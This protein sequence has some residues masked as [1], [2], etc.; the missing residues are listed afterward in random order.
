MKK[1]LFQ[2]LLIM[3]I[4]FLMPACYKL[5]G[6]YGGPKDFD[7]NARSIVDTDIAV[8]I[9]YKVDAM[10]TSL[11]YPTGITFD[12][13]GNIFVIES[14]YS[15]GEIWTA[16]RLLQ[17]S[18][19]GEHFEIAKGTDNGPWNG[20]DYKDGFF[21]VSEG[22]TKDGGRI[23]KISKS[24]EVTSL[25]KNLPIAADH[26][27]NGPVVGIDG[28]VYFGQGTAT[29]SGVVGLDNYEYGW[30][31]RHPDLHDI[32]CK[33]IVLNGENFKTENP[34]TEQKDKVTTGAFSAF[35]T[36][37]EPNQSIKGALPC[38]GAIF[39]VPVSGGDLELYAWGLRN[40]FGLAFGTNGK[41]YVTENSY[42]TR[43]SRPGYGTGDVLWTINKGSWYGWPDYSA[44]QPLNTK[45]YKTP[46]QD[47]EK[48]LAEDPQTPPKPTAILEVHS[49]AA[50]L[51]FSRNENFGYIGEAFIAEFGDM[52]PEVGRIY[53]PVGYKIVRVNVSNGMI[54]EF[55]SN[56]GRINGPASQ[57]KSGGIER[58]ISVKFDP[59]GTTLYVLDFG[60]MPIT[61]NGPAPK[62]QTGTIWRVSRTDVAKSNY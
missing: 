59:T 28:Y 44:G 3:N 13:N 27:T 39:R 36:T 50:G 58:P 31:K 19:S 6:H 51:D 46:H 52:A 21:Y 38:H 8:P 24:G 30:L 2:H 43:G 25:V 11:S 42:D 18:S 47:P 14:G 22:G 48:L 15:Y 9:G 35:G 5:R 49:S 56:K 54:Y 60:I 29:N 23:L 4:I 32:P 12:E 7:A 61:K 17:I 1:Y 34:L 57:I 20:I 37:T 16:P 45:D 26:H 41:L 55:M 53:G 40:P 10:T 33:D 62:Q